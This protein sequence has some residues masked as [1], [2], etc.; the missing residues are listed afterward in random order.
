MLNATLAATIA[1][2]YAGLIALFRARLRDRELAEDLINEAFAESL[3][4]LAE[5]RIADPS[6]FSG[7]VYR[8][9]FNLLRNHR[10]RMDNRSDV[11]VSAAGLEHLSAE[12]PLPE[13]CLDAY[14]GERI[15]QAV[16]AL[17]VARDREL[18]QRF[19][20]REQTKQEICRDLALS[21]AHFN[22]ILFRARQRLGQRLSALNLA[23]AHAAVR[24]KCSAAPAIKEGSDR[25][26][27]RRSE[28]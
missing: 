13:H 14:T 3:G 20:L 6:R 8:V 27:V 23:P 11:R 21:P 25:G 10:R 18:I 2:D 9:A 26:P 15:R 22:K 12:G 16:A 7:Y 19:Y 24:A 17:P 28:R 4:Q 5:Q 1:A